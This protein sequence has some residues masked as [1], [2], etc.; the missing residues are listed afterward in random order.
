MKFLNY[1]WDIVKRY[2]WKSKNT[3]QSSEK[4]PFVTTHHEIEEEVIH[5]AENNETGLVPIKI[6]LSHTSNDRLGPNDFCIGYDKIEKDMKTV[7]Y[8]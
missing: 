6:Y 4:T 5:F 8:L 1:L 2:L 3:K 7:V